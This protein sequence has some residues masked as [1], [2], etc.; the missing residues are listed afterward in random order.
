MKKIF[1]SLLMLGFAGVSRS[2]LAEQIDTGRGDV[3]RLS[4]TVTAILRINEQAKSVEVVF[5]KEAME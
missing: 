3:D 1:I 4:C 5:Y 2:V